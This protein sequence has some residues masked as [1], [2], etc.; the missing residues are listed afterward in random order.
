MRIN[1]SFINSLIIELNSNSYKCENVMTSV[2]RRDD[3]DTVDSVRTRWT[4]FKTSCSTFRLQEFELKQFSGFFWLNGEKQLTSDRK[5]R[6][7]TQ[8]MFMETLYIRDTASVH[9][10]QPL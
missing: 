7:R 2:H 8:P 5:Q 3:V 4:C 9:E 1:N 10:G 6:G